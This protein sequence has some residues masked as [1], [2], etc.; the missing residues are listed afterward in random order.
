MMGRDVEA[1]SRFECALALNPAHRPALT[2][3][4]DL[5]YRAGRLPAAIALYEHA[6]RQWPDDDDV[7]D[8]L[9]AWR[10]EDALQRRLVEVRTEHFTVMF[11]HAADERTAREIGARLEAARERI[12]AALGVVPPGSIGV[13]LYQRER[14]TDVTKLAAWSA[15]AYDG[16]IHLPLGGALDDGEELDRVLSH[17]L[18]H[19]VVASV[20][21]RTV[22]AWLNEGL[23]TV[24]EPAGSADA[25]APLTKTSTRLALSRLHRFSGFTRTEAELAYASAARAVRTLIERRGAAPLV[26]L[27]EDLGRG[28]SFAPAFERRIAMRYEEFAALV[29]RE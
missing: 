14:F 4:A 5:H 28:A 25:E 8:R 15:A 24:L 29:N 22:P 26:A 6:Q 18:V 9:E 10:K 7:R 1:R 12:A 13:V 27:L 21:G 23:A 11:E 19:A 3:L 2:W 20:A 17:E 16:R